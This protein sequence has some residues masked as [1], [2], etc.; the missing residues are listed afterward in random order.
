MCTRACVCVCV[1][2]GVVVVVCVCVCVCGVC[3]WWGVAF[4][5][6][7]VREFV[8]LSLSSA[9]GLHFI[10]TTQQYYAPHFRSAKGHMSPLCPLFR[11]HCHMM[12]TVYD[13]I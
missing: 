3:V 12:Y 5:W 10:Y 2:G 13:D 8:I 1:C 9:V 7:V 4:S 6:E 11:H